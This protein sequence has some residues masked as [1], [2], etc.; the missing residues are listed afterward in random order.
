MKKI[1]V[2]IGGNALVTPG[3][4]GDI[5][6]QFRHSREMAVALA[7]LVELGWHV[8][9]THGN[10]PQVGS[11][12]RRVE[13][14]SQS[15]YP[16][17]LG[18]AVAD[19]QAGMG[20]MISQTL[21]NE[22]HHRGIERL[23][24]SVVTSVVVD[25]LDPAFQNPTKPI[26][27]FLDEAAARRHREKDGWQIVEDSGRGYRRV[28]PSPRPLR[29]V[30]ID[31]LRDLVG[32]DYLL[33]ACGGGGIPVIENEKGELHGVE[34]VIDKDLTS[35]LF[36]AQIEADVLVI[37]TGVES[38]FINYGKPDQQPLRRIDLARIQ[39]LTTQG[40]FAQGSM[41]PKI[42]AAVDFVRMSHREDARAIITDFSDLPA[43]L[44]GRNGTTIVRQE[45]KQN[46]RP[47]MPAG[48]LTGR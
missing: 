6:D 27:P 34:A 38:V 46:Q 4:T 18:L 11:I 48:A 22:L 1:V 30:E 35:S 5:S 33:V 19:T 16:I 8:T 3:S 36:A 47:K 10:G 42:Q 40:H 24:T 21:R 15:V 31:V 12:M 39:Q 14:S 32:R 44:Q 20:Y 7:N 25:P 17:D 28:V 2:A 37:L 29:I 45:D 9:V 13:L 26:G 41:L 23:C 43:A